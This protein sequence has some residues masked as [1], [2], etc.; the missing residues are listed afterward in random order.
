M[1]T[2]EKND[3]ILVIGAGPVGLAVAKSLKN[4]NVP[5]LQVEA[6]N[7]VGGNWY[8]GVY[9]TAN[10]LSSR[11]ATEYPDFPMPENYPDFPSAKQMHEYYRI[12]TEHFNLR[13]NIRFNTKVISVKPVKNNLWLAQFDTGETI[14]FKGVAVCN[15]HHWSKRYPTIQGNFT[16]EILHS[17]EYKSPEQLRGKRILV[18][19]AGN[20][21]FDIS[22]EGARVGEKCFLSVR[23]GIW[24]FPKTFMGKPLSAFQKIKLPVWV[25]KRIGKLMLKMAIGNPQEYGLP[26]PEID[27]FSR[28]PTI[29]TDTLIHIKNGRITVKGGIKEFA[30]KNVHFLDD[31][32]EEVDLVVFA[33]GFHVDF[34]FLPKALCR[35]EESTVKVYGYGMYE[36]YK[37]LYIVGWFQPRGGVGSLIGPYSD[38]LAEWIKVQDRIDVPIGMVLKEQGE[39][40]ANTHLFGGPETVAWIKKQMKRINKFE[41]NGKRLSMK[42][43]SF[44]NKEIEFDKSTEINQKVY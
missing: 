39:K 25:K 8:H 5:Y 42:N 1:E 4:A 43:K 26:K 37:G 24:I 9:P 11:T 3:H 32:I 18:V 16:G 14:Q 30:G 27:V 22:S 19:G 29:D 44:M 23:R 2:I 40:I 38:L 13:E 12:Y 31:S 20:S 28:H 17:K 33:T 10:I 7:D 34:P 35:V 41:R 36:D 15:G 6:D 21:A